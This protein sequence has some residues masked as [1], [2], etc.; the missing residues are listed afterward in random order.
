MGFYGTFRYLCI[1]KDIYCITPKTHGNNQTHK[2][3]SISGTWNIRW[4]N[5]YLDHVIMSLIISNVK[6]GNA[7]FSSRGPMRKPAQ[8]CFTYV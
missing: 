5:L 1:M 7:L 4:S 3:C 2:P 8:V 6:S